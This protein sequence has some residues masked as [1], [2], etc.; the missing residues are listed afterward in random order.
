MRKL[1]SEMTYQ[2]RPL[3]EGHPDLA[4]GD[5]ETFPRALD[6]QP[7]DTPRIDRLLTCLDRVVDLRPPKDV[8]IVGC[9]PRPQTIRALSERGYQA[10]GVEPIPAF[11]RAAEEYLGGSNE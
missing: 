1:D 10:T 2:D 5:L 9:G 11:V 6:Q 3:A 4:M 8:L 7:D